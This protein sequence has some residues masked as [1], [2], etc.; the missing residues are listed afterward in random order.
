VIH[1]SLLAL[2]SRLNLF[3]AK[4]FLL[5]KHLG[6]G[7]LSFDVFLSLSLKILKSL[8]LR[9]LVLNEH[10]VKPILLL[11][12]LCLLIQLL[13]LLLILQSHSKLH[14]SLD[15]FLDDVF[16]LLL[17][18]EELLVSARLLVLHLFLN[19][20]LL[21]T[22]VLLELFEMLK[23]LLVVLLVLSHLTLLADTSISQLAIKFKLDD[24]FA[25]KLLIVSSLLLLIVDQGIELNDGIQLVILNLPGFSDL[26]K[27]LFLRLV[28]RADGEQSSCGSLS[29]L[30]GSN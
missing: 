16:L 5:L 6:I 13:L 23:L 29:V 14:V 15:L 24:S 30:C 17:L 8:L 10:L 21:L 12:L 28:V 26:R 2:F 9:P 7:L 3:H 18:L 19:E 25:L 4:L 11:G 27:D 20:S 22:L 1:K